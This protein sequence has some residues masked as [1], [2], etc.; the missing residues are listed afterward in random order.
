MY[1]PAIVV[2]TKPNGSELIVPSTDADVCS[3]GGTQLELQSTCALAQSRRLGQVGRV[4]EG[5]VLGLSIDDGGL[6][7]RALGVWLDPLR[8]VPLAFVSH[9]HAARAA[10]GSAR[11]LASPETL[12]LA[13]ALGVEVSSAQAVGWDGAVELPLEGGSGPRARVSIAPAGH[14]LGAAQLVVEH[15]GGKLVYTGDWS[16]E[17]DPTRPGGEAVACD[18][19]VVTTSFA[20]P[21]FRF[22]P[23]AAVVS[24]LVD[25]C[26]DRLAA[27]V[28]PIVLAATPG[29]AQV[30]AR[31]LSARGL[32]A[33]GDDEVRR[34]CAAYEALGVVLGPLRP[35]E[36]GARGRAVIAHAGARASELRARGRV[37]VAYASAW[38]RLDAAVEQ[39]RA[40]AAFVLADQADYDGLLGLVHATGAKHVT[41]TRGDARAFAHLLRGRG[42]AATA[43]ELAPIDERRAS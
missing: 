8:A 32:P 41:A 31:A 40:D 21:I 2:P 42:V 26:A 4:D 34:G 15:G 37:E 24:A 7:L 10:E 18:E 28:T 6:C 39:K 36:A 23:A 17:G 38:A 19:L 35:H 30:V 25:W 13:A 3:A 14:L 9:A 33:S 11:M 43:L 22:E 29:P 1:R 16:A 20:L 27:G 5:G 12:G